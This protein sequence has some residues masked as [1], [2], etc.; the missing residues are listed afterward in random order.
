MSMMSGKTLVSYFPCHSG[1]RRRTKRQDLTLSLSLLFFLCSASNVSASSKLRT[2]CLRIWLSSYL[3]QGHKNLANGLT[4][5]WDNSWEIEK[6][7]YLLN[8][9]SPVKTFGNCSFK[10]SWPCHQLGFLT[11]WILDLILD[12]NE[13]IDWTKWKLF[14]CSKWEDHPNLQSS[15]TVSSSSRVQWRICAWCVIKT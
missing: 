8:H 1:I 7:F 3:A 15:K 12:S 2:P 11:I 6:H 4:R 5:F 13:Y 10:A 9:F 14:R